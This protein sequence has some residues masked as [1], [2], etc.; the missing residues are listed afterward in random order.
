[1]IARYD[2][3]FSG[4]FCL[5]MF[6]IVIGAGC[7]DTTD[8]P[9][10]YALSGTVTYDGKPVPKG[11]ITLEPNSEQ[12]NSGPGG[13]ADIVNGKYDTKA[14]MGIV[15]GPYKVRITGTDGMPTSIEGEELPDGK[16]LFL[17]F[18]TTVD[19]PKQASVRDFE[20]PIAK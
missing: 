4:G 3:R 7:G 15:G 5:A 17:P 1:M 18:E 10:R 6:L 9:K 14:A 20:I 12:G 13:G 11:F 19:L 16:P 8:G 2:A